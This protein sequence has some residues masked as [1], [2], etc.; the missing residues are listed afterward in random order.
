MKNSL[1]LLAAAISGFFIMGM[2]GLSL[3]NRNAMVNQSALLDASGRLANWEAVITRELFLLNENKK[4]NFTDLTQAQ[5]AHA[6]AFADILAHVGDDL[7][8][9]EQEMTQAFEEERTFIEAYKTNWSIARNSQQAVLRY[10]RMIKNQAQA[11]GSLEVYGAITDIIYYMNIAPIATM[12]DTQITTQIAAVE[13]YI[14]AS[15]SEG[16]NS[17]WFDLKRHLGVFEAANAA[18]KDALNAFSSTPLVEISS[19]TMR[20]QSEVNARIYQQEVTR[21]NTTFLAAAAFLVLILALIGWLE[22]ALRHKRTENDRLDEAVK[23]RT[24]KLEESVAEVKRL[25]DAKSSFL[26]NMSHEIR[27]PMNGVIGMSELLADT[28]LNGDQSLYAKTIKES[29]EAL[30]TIINDILDLSKAESGKMTLDAQPFRLDEMLENL[31]QL[32][33]VTAKMKNVEIILNY[34]PSAERGFIGDSGRIRQVLMNIV[35][36]AVKFTKEGHV[37]IDIQCTSKNG[38]ADLSIAVSDTGI[39]ICE[40]MLSSIFDSFIQADDSARREFQ[41]TG[42]GLAISKRFMEAMGGTIAVSSKLGAGSTFTVKAALP[43]ADIDRSPQDAP[44]DLAQLPPLRLLIVDDI[45]LNRRILTE[46][47]KYYGHHI[48][49][50]RNALETL[51]ALHHAKDAGETFDLAF[52]DYQMPHMDGLELAHRIRTDYPSLD[53]PIIILSSVSGLSSLPEYE[54]IS[55]LYYLDKPAPSHLLADTVFKALGKNRQ[56][57]PRDAEEKP[58]VKAFGAGFKLLVVE[59]TK[60]NQLVIR[61]IAEKAGF[62][63]VF[64]N[65]GKEGVDLFNREAPDIILMDWSMPVMSGLEA[66]RVIRETEEKTGAAATPIIG[67]SANAMKEHAEDGLRAGMNA[68]LTKPIKKK[69]LLNALQEY[70]HAGSSETRPPQSVA[71]T[72]LAQS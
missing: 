58:D 5:K 72:A 39:G 34:P 36:N 51:E 33:A 68:Y 53:F 63:I 61:K 23:E 17:S 56:R 52:L 49:T 19:E 3:K 26:A 14:G 6:V 60:T 25:A 46:R 27:T 32:V 45:E 1:L 64:A 7:S 35:G 69:D 29:A 43:I 16:L 50:A 54:G 13:R 18:K 28:P 20:T 70:A 22:A 71:E 24:K 15:G 41:G 57:P 38:V 21:T 12:E 2:L 67:L 44:A 37:A 10:S 9:L 30:L 4:N 65:N 11:G 31:T 40:S 8:D 59:D 42:L 62:D 48:A 66:T 55:Q 47:F